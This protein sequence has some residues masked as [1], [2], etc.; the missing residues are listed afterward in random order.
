[1]T[2]KI[3]K[4][5][6]WAA[7]LAVVGALQYYAGVSLNQPF[8]LIK[9]TAV[10]FFIATPLIIHEMGHWAMLHRYKVPIRSVHLGMGPSFLKLG[11]LDLKLLPIGAAI[12][13]EPEEYAAV[14][15]IRK[16]KVAIAGPI[17]SAIYAALCYGLALAT[18]DPLTA[19]TLMYIA[20]FNAILFVANIVPIPPL[21]GFHILVQYYNH[22][23]DPIPV[24]YHRMFNRIGNGVVYGVGFFALGSVFFK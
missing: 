7:A 4:M 1:M 9:L 2:N 23:Q 12:E 22:I 10:L 21:D 19:K 20:H 5:G 3:Y 13:P 8:F 24:K 11:K 18:I 6:M 14:P 17:A 16:I 15:P